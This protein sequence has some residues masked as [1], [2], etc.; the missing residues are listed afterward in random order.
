MYFYFYIFI[1]LDFGQSSSTCNENKVLPF[2][3]D[4]VCV[5]SKLASTI[6]NYFPYTQ[7]YYKL[8]AIQLV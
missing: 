6:T 1:A 2:A 8:R 4:G 7:I 3:M 5:C